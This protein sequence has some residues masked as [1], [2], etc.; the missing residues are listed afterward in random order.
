[1]SG[2]EALTGSTE[3]VK[4]DR[5]VKGSFGASRI[6]VG[7]D[8]IIIGLNHADS[9]GERGQ[10]VLGKGFGDM[11]SHFFAELNQAEAGA[12]ID[13]GILIEASTLEQIGDE[14]DID[15][16]EIAWARDDEATA[17]AFGFGFAATGEAVAFND[18]G[19]GGSRGKVF[20]AMVLEQ[21]K[22][23]Q[24]AEAS[25]STQLQDPSAQTSFHRSR[26]VIGAVGM[27]QERRAVVVSPFKALFPFV[28]RFSRDAEP[29]TSQGDIAEGL[30][31]QEPVIALT[32]LLL[33]RKVC[34]GHG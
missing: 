21:L 14:F 32:N 25:F 19:D 7:E 17:V 6:P 20:K 11:G 13:G 22:Q 30:S 8:G 27:I 26:A 31:F 1:M 23:T 12:A 18:F 5:A 28:E 10:D 9:K 15:L 29:F 4:F 16:D 24:G 34:L 2:P 3:G 33:W